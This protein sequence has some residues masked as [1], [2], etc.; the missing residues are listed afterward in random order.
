MCHRICC[1]GSTL[2]EKEMR[3]K[4]LAVL[5]K[6]KLP[7]QIFTNLSSLREC[8]RHS[9]NTQHLQLDLW[10]KLDPPVF[11]CVVV[12]MRRIWKEMAF[13]NW[14]Y[15]LSCKTE[16]CECSYAEGCQ[17]FLG[18]NLNCPSG[19]WMWSQFLWGELLSLSSSSV[20]R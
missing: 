4:I 1:S 14:K 15:I 9:W 8:R 3:T 11:K 17:L 19:A 6:T 16:R 13:Q 5:S 2:E 10:I 18:N 12:K 20:C 7:G